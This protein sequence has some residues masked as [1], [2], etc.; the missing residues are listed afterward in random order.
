MYAKFNFGKLDYVY[1]M[2]FYFFKMLFTWATII[3][4]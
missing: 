2:A 1:E 4:S 3:L